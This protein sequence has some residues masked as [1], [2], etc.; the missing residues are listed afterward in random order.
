V[1]HARREYLPLT[2]E[3]I[4][5]HLSGHQH[6][7]LYPLRDGSRRW[8]LAADFAGP[9]AMLDTLAYLTAA[10]PLAVPAALEVS[11]SG[12]GAHARVFFTAPAPAETARRLGT[13][14]LRAAR[15]CRRASSA[16]WTM[17]RRLARD[18]S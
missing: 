8:W 6:L 7:G 2:T 11:R 3:T 16:I 14:L 15:P 1:P 18:T 13:G 17:T 9:G 12:V 10:R 4:T 5:A